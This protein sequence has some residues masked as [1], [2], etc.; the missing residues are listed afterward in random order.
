MIQAWR[1]DLI[2][3][4]NS[5]LTRCVSDSHSYLLLLQV[6]SLT[7]ALAQ[8]VRVPENCYQLQAGRTAHRTA[9]KKYS[10]SEVEKQEKD[11]KP[12]RRLPTCREVSP[13]VFPVTASLQLCII[14]SP[15]AG[16]TGFGHLKLRPR[17]LHFSQSLQASLLAQL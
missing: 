7:T 4:C 17:L 5:C 1:Y 6:G 13:L 16:N 3:A 2:G 9:T 11:R 14:P 15:T 10:T 12:R 8:K